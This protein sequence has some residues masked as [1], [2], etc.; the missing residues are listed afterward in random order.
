MIIGCVVFLVLALAVSGTGQL[1]QIGPDDSH[2]CTNVEHIK[3]N[4][5]VPSS[6][7]LTG[8]LEDQSGAPIKNSHIE[9]RRYISEAKQVRTAQ[10]KPSDNGNFDLG[11][12]SKGNYR[13]LASP[14]RAFEQPDEIWCNSVHQCFLRIILKANSTDLPASQCPIR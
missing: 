5:H 4:L 14:T 10:A 12:V 3:A 1:I 11:D 8:H 7:Q 9:L 2:Y 13:L 6:V